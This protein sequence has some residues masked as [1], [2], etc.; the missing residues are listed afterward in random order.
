MG[1][2]KI[3][4]HFLVPHAD[5]GQKAYVLSEIDSI[6]YMEFDFNMRFSLMGVQG[7]RTGEKIN[8]MGALNCPQIRFD[9]VITCIIDWFLA[10]ASFF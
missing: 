2:L 7:Q 9:R 10:N 3:N 6:L 8:W 4:I 5:E 1:R